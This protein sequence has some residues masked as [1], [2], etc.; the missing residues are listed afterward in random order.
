M[1]GTERWDPAAPACQKMIVAYSNEGTCNVEAFGVGHRY[2]KEFV[3]A[4]SVFEAEGL[5]RCF[6]VLFR[7][8]RVE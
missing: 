3:P 6:E 1:L 7:Y 8:L 5:Q 4:L 2:L